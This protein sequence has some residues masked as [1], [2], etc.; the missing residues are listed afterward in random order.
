MMTGLSKHL[1]KLLDKRK[2]LGDLVRHQATDVLDWETSELENIFALLI[3]GSF[4]GIPSTPT[5]ITLNLL[6]HMENELQVM[7]EKVVTAAGPISDLFSH[8]DSP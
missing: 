2:F 7:M 1:K 8:L 6:P 4:V 5:A 3:F